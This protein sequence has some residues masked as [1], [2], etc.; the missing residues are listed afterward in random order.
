VSDVQASA[1]VRYKH[2]MH[3]KAAQRMAVR[4]F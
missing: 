3:K 2:E 1:T 4:G